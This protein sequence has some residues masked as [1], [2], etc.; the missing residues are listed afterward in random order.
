MQAAYR[1]EVTRQYLA[2][3]MSWHQRHPTGQLLSN[4][5]S[6][7]EAAWAPIAP[8]PMAVGTIA[9]MVIAVV[10]MLLADPP[11]AV[12]G[13]VVFPL[14]IV[15]NVVYQRL[16]S[17]LVTR[18]QS[19]RA[20]LSETAHESFDGALVVKTLGRESE[21]TERFWAQA[22]ALRDLGVRAGRIRAAFDPILE[23][24]PNL[25]I[26]GVL[27]L[28]VARVETGAAQPGEIVTIAY[29][30]TIVAF[31]VRSIGWL[32]GEFP[33]SVVGY[34]RVHR[35]LDETLSQEHGQ[36]RVDPASSGARLSVEGLG[37]AHEDGPRVLAGLDLDLEPGRTLA[38]VGATASG[39]STLTT[40]L[41]RLVDPDAGVVRLDGHDLRDLAPG[42][43]AEHAALVPQAAFLFDDTVRGNVTLGEEV[44]DEEVWAALR[45]AQAEDFV[46]RLPLG[47]DTPLGERGTTL[48]GGQ[49]QRLSLARALVRRPRLLVMDDATSAVD[50]EVEQRILAAMREGRSEAP[51]TMVLVAY[52][53][54]T[55]ALADEVAFLSG[56]RIADRGTHEEL[57]ARNPDYAR[58][59][60]AYDAEEVPA[61]FRHSPELGAGLRVTLLL[62]VL[63]ALGRVVVPIA[64]QQTLDRGLGGGDA[65]AGAVDVGFV[66]RMG[67]VAAV[68]VLVTGVSSYLMTARLFTAAERGLATLRTK[69]F[70]HVHD[71][72]LLTQS[73]ERR[74]ALVS[75]VTSDVDQVSQFL[76]FGGIVAVVSVL[77]VLV[78]TV[79]MLSYSWELTLVVWLCF[80]PLFVSLRH[81]QRRL[82][83]AYG[84]VRRQV[85][86][87]LSAI[88]EPVVGAAVV[89]THAIEGRT[90]ERIDTAVS[91]TQ[92]AYTKAQGLTAV[93][94]SLGGLSSGLANAGV[95]VVGVLL[96]LAGGLSSGE[97][98][99]F[100]FL[101]TLFVGPV[102]NGTQVLT[103]AQNA[104]AGWRRVIGIL[105]TPADLS[106]PG[107]DGEPLPQGALEIDFDGVGFAYPGG[108]P[109]LV[110]VD[111]RLRPGSRVAVVGETGSGK[112]TF[113]KLLTRLMDP[114]EGAVRLGG[115]D[116]R[117]VSFATL[118]RR[119][120]MVPQEGFL[121]D[122][123]LL[124]NVRYGRAGA[125]E[126]DV[127]RAAAELGLDDWLAGL[128][129]GVHTRVGQRGESLSAGERQLVALLRA[130]LADPDL[131][132]LDE[133]TS[134]V[135]PELETRIG[136][137]LERVMSGRTSVTIAH[138]L[139]TAEHAD[140]VL[141]FD[142]GR[143]VQRGPHAT[144]VEQGG[145]YGRLHASWVSQGRT[146]E[147]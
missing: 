75:R 11:T 42:A 7:V 41:L 61:G 53:K 79:V 12:V 84:Y 105:D 35:V 139:S 2:L 127:R 30:L 19:T 24:L 9:M 47:L 131:L 72:P 57:L 103:D 46:R 10:Q 76:V 94:F 15:A 18:I 13:L 82:S 125:S 74:G 134:A 145:V 37:Y 92:R 108:P 136:R 99:A 89:R 4:A 143:V 132:V 107:A 101:V 67:L 38:L 93:T 141:V 69:A 96:G 5:N 85:G 62:A 120:V 32:V 78:A 36:V 95:I 129:E 58:L 80:V 133:A 20:D 115:V 117:A 3:P 65:G 81:F 27:A 71:L 14:V 6:D 114:T 54:A 102:Q 122:S 98:L 40:L 66:V 111:E 63:G 49:R 34:E 97:V 109:V 31:P 26:L 29:L 130:H 146:V 1:R 68:A 64:V 135:D 147:V 23:A 110:E 140:E 112:T 144:L 77:Q 59:V 21:E 119:V 83:A 70:R 45:T 48:S 44:D 88:S 123:T 50:P 25:A 56:G 124:A 118:R 60:N 126:D 73:T 87:M 91:N 137:A 8:L 90:Q 106:D 138:R 16:S 100:S 128:P 33:R 86:V 55:I 51:A 28:G 104:I 43:L 39:K 113:A 142:A 17:P 116:L 121:F 52:R 22:S